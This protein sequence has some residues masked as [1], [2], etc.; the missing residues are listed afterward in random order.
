MSLVA[1]FEAP[2]WQ[3]QGPAAW[4]FVTLPADLA[5]R[6]LERVEGGGS[7]FG[8]VPVQARVGGTTWRTSL[9]PDRQAASY[10]LPMKKS[11]RTSNGLEPGDVVTVHL[12]VPAPTPG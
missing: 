3:Y 11:V 6:V 9:F 8:A 10:L 1:S 7:P 4:C 2:L 5:D 12:T